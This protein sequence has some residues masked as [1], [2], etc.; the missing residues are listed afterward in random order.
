MN[1]L[2][3]GKEKWEFAF[4]MLFHLKQQRYN[5]ALT[6]RTAVKHTLYGHLSRGH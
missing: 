1:T 2:V 4:T 6:L 3:R 5:L